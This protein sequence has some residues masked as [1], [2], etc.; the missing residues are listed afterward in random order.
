MIFGIVVVIGLIWYIRQL[1]MNT[2]SN[3]CY[4]LSEQ[5]RPT[6]LSSI[7]YTDTMYELPLH[8]YMIKT[9][10][11]SCA[12]GPFK[13]SWVDL[14]ALTSVI[15]QGCRVLDFEVYNIQ[16]EPAVA[17]SSTVG[18]YEKGTYNSIPFIQVI[19]CIA[20][21]AFTSSKCPNSNDPLF[22]N[23][24]IKSSHQ[25][26]YNKMATALERLD[27]RMLSS[28]YS[29][30]YLKDGVSSNLSNVPLRNLIGK[31]IVMVDTKT[32]QIQY[33]KLYEYV[34]IAGN[35]MFM[36][37]MDN[38]SIQHDNQSDTIDFN[39][40]QIT[41]STPVLADRAVN[42][43]A[44]IMKSYGVQMI[45]MCFQTNYTYDV[46]LQ[47]Y[48]QWFNDAR[49]AFL[50]KAPTLRGVCQEV[51]ESTVVI[52]EENSYAPKV[53]ESPLVKLEL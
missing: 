36:R 44:T 12:T 42:Y 28:E 8:S 13:R 43:D 26:I 32:I 14:C 20:E 1:A 48:I 16:G 3:A 4:R 37:I 52:P 34:N 11:N 30:E 5:E 29:Y 46:N 7:S 15:S 2:A 25:D 49:S 18:F 50:M 31:V 6:T 19:Q 24:R 27:D 41:M 10:Y 35:S 17:A 23:F 9:S 33:S 53:I 38:E 21:N 51:V 40:C 45:A 47:V 39:K 22:L